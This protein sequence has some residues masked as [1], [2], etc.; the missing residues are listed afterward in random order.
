VYSQVRSSAH[1]LWLCDCF[2]WLIEHLRRS[3]SFALQRLNLWRTVTCGV[4]A[5]WS[6]L[7]GLTMSSGASV[8][9]IPP[10]LLCMISVDGGTTNH[11]DSDHGRLSTLVYNGHCCIPVTCA[12]I[13]NRSSDLRPTPGINGPTA[14]FSSSTAGN[15]LHLS[16]APRNNQGNTQWESAG[17]D[18]EA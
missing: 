9:S 11:A 13:V 5:G 4:G 3:T 1:K 14:G 16:L 6:F 17:S 12:R 2:D 8:I 10:K 7:I 18:S 15:P